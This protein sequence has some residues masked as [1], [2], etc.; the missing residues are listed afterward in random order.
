MVQVK[1]LAVILAVVICLA[2]AQDRPVRPRPGTRPRPG[3]RPGARP[4]PGS[5]PGTRP[6]TRPGARPGARPD[7]REFERNRMQKAGPLNPQARAFTEENR[8]D[9]EITLRG[10]RNPK[11]W[12]QTLENLSG[13]VFSCNQREGE[14]QIPRIENGIAAYY[15]GRRSDSYSYKVFFGES[16]SLRGGSGPRGVSG[17]EKIKQ[18]LQAINVR[19]SSL[20]FN[21]MNAAYGCSMGHC[22]TRYAETTVKVYCIFEFETYRRP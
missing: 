8:R 7:P 2:Y 6:G 14:Y 20:R 16:D 13:T 17:D 10:L 18:A 11:K 5:R 9:A 3:S 15:K 21:Y 19:F 22:P 12:D 1:L 4:G